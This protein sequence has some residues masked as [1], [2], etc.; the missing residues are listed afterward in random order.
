MNRLA[1]CVLWVGVAAT[2]FCARG[3]ARA[4]T[5]EMKLKKTDEVSGRLDPN[6]RNMLTWTSSQ[7]F[8]T[9]LSGERPDL[10][11]AFR[12]VVKKQ[13]EK[14]QCDKPFRCVARLGGEEY[15][16][17]FDSTD[18]GKKGY[19][20]LHFDKNRNGDLTD[21]D[22]IKAKS[23]G[24]R[25]WNQGLYAEFPELT[26]PI[27]AGDS[28]FDYSFKV[29]AEIYGSG[30]HKWCQASLQSAV[31]RE[32]EIT[33][34]GK[35]RPVYLL[36]FNSNGRF[37]DRYTVNREIRSNDNRV[38]PSDGDILLVDPS[39]QSAAINWYDPTVNDSRLYVSKVITIDGKFHDLT[40]SPT[41]DK[42][43]IE[44]SKAAVGYIRNPKADFRALVYDDAGILRI[45][46]AKGA[47]VALPE[48]EWRLL[49][50]TIDLTAASQ[51]ATKPAEKP[52]RKGG[53]F[54]RLFS[55]VAGSDDGDSIS[56]PRPTMIS[57]A[58]TRDYKP[59]T[60]K[61]GETVE[62]PFGPPYKPAVRVEEWRRSKDRAEL[63]MVLTG[64]AGEI[65]TD[66]RVKGNQP[67][68]P[69][70]AIVAP[71]GEVIERGKFEY[72]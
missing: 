6:I 34:D 40:I 3:T 20:R 52:A 48:G 45:S 39:V 32:G 46:G 26:L 44:P 14:Y 70:F 47:P 58:G 21:D 28:Q 60:V 29:S 61:K 11:E 16:M 19:N 2:A 9:D 15:G 33:L 5:C 17:V 67:D 63:S 72:G 62:L 31:Y 55:S 66:L 50:Y 22:L 24:S 65:C 57:A 37:D 69:T 53:L 49:S 51:P 38:W 59:V 36:D 35:K 30:E 68:A 4:E 54:R 13:P 12:K 23:T 64:S 8:W 10:E 7:G 25:P 1:R 18:L 43:T 71:D 41:G 27:K 42:L 56:T